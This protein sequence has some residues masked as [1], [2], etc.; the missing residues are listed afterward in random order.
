[1]EKLHNLFYE[2]PIGILEIKGTDEAIHSI[3]FV[4]KEKAENNIDV[5]C[6]LVLKICSDQLDE[7]FLGK[8][9]EFTIPII[10]NGT[11]FQQSVWK[12]LTTIPHGNTVSYKQIAEGLGNPKAV[13]AVGGANNKNKLSIIVPCHRVISADG[14][15]TGYAGG[16]WRKEWLLLHEKSM[17]KS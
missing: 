5:E 6:P 14:K 1:M 12:S 8:R 11:I 10:L 7:Y 13:R 2:S 4:E 16:L 17:K 9:T 15:L 3:M